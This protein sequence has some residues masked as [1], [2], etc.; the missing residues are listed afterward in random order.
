MKPTP[1]N[2]ETDLAPIPLFRLGRLKVNEPFSYLFDA[3]PIYSEV[4]VP[5]S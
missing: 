5:N 4:K 1:F 2:P 3:F